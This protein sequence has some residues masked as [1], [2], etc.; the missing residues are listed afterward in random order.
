MPQL[1]FT[2]GFVIVTFFANAQVLVPKKDYVAQR[3][4]TRHS[5]TVCLIA[6]AN[7]S[8]V[9]FGIYSLRPDSTVSVL[10]LTPDA[11]V[12]QFRGV[13]ES[14][15]NPDRVDLCALHQIDSTVFAKVWKL[16]YDQYPFGPPDEPG[17]GTASGTPS[18]A[19]F[20]MLSQFGIY[21]ITDHCYGDNLYKLLKQLGNNVWVGQYMQLK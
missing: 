5:F 4:L 6:G 14:V 21:T 9:S 8:P 7:S 13:E 12:R 18:Q 3:H 19:Q 1:L 20:N 11:F 10:Y 17:W 15:A 2:I 16:K